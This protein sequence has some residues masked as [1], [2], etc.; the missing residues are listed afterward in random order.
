MGY[1]KRLSGEGAIASSNLASAGDGYREFDRN[2]R[3][4]ELRPRY[5]AGQQT[6]HFRSLG[7]NHDF[8]HRDA[9]VIAQINLTATWVGMRQGEVVAGAAIALIHMLTLEGRVRV[10]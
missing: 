1:C 8:R 7:L 9:F 3:R 5:R 10:R 6:Y 2:A 4:Q